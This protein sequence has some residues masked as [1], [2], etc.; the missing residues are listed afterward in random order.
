M[1]SI[2][3]IN[4]LAARG[5]ELWTQQ[6]KLQ[7]KA[8][9][10][11]VT[12]QLLAEL[13]QHKPTL[14]GLLEQFGA[15]AGSYPLSYSQKSLWSLYQMQPQSAAYNVT[16]AARLTDTL[17]L[18]A[19]ARCVDYLIARHP[20]LRTRYAVVDG[21]PVQQVSTAASARLVVDT[22]FDAS[23]G[24]IHEWVENEANKPFQLEVSPI[25]LK[26]L[27]NERRA[28]ASAAPHYVL[29][30][31]VHHIA[32][33]FRSL[34]IMVRE[35]GELYRLAAQQLPPRLP[36]LGVHYKDWVQHEVERLQGA[37]GAELAA[38][39]DRELSMPVPALALQT[40]RMRPPLKTENGRVLSLPLGHELAGAVRQA[41]KASQ[42]TPYMLLLGVYE[43]FLFLHTGQT[44]LAI[45][46]PTSGR[47]LPGCE[48]VLGHFVNTVVLVPELQADQPFRELLERTRA[49]MLR[50]LD[51]QDFPFPLLVERLRP[52]RDPSRSPLFQVMYNWNQVRSAGT[53]ADGSVEPLWGETIVAS[54]TGTRGATHDL[55]LNIQDLGSEYVAAWAF[56]TDLFDE[57]TIARFAHQY[58]GL[59]QQVLD[60]AARP[61]AGYRLAPAVT[62]A[63]ALEAMARRSSD[64]PKAALPSELAAAL[65]RRS[66]QE[67]AWRLPGIDVSVGEIAGA[68]ERLH[69]RLK[70]A[71]VGAQ[72]VV[73][74]QLSS[75]PEL[76]LAWH[77]LMRLQSAV[78]TCE[79]QAAAAVPSGVEFQLRSESRSWGDWN[80]EAIELIDLSAPALHPEEA[81]A[82]VT[83][84]QL[85]HF[86]KGLGDGLQLTATCQPLLLQGTDLRLSAAIL[87]KALARDV[88]V[89]VPSDTSVAALASAEQ[90]KAEAGA[91]ALGTAI[92]RLQHGVLA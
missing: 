76:A 14:I 8:P 24:A 40:D 53:G 19:L 38:F 28:A 48:G 84:S 3:Y 33:D 58:L 83:S 71:G 60:D 4:E 29:L 39:W 70:S 36:P 90:G 7:Y 67:V 15:T 66:K 51:H 52:A 80:P 74:V 23:L 47:N 43:L 85:A 77:A 82:A 32:A 26:L 34:E 42:V 56:N 12:P 92:G 54:S 10:E 27:V 72:S 59:V 6:G 87:L 30:L 45:G 68:A 79:P 65:A 49:M 75:A 20:I 11:A 63:L 25:R 2:A 21:Q 13:K 61:L 50:V 9:K 62:R 88:A 81:A 91:Q 16:Y 73:G 41:A 57:A 78:L 64:A 69:E 31:N 37:E 46:A 22:V 55:T 17:D 86:I 18:A 5:I 44:R 1:S 89:T 35:L